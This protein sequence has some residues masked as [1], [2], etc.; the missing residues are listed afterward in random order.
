[1][2]EKVRDDRRRARATHGLARSPG[3]VNTL[4]NL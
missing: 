4:Y 2:N 3:A 1:M